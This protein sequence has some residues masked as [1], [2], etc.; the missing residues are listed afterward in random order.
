MYILWVALALAGVDDVEVLPD[1]EVLRSTEDY[2]EGWAAGA[3]AGEQLSVRDPA[4]VGAAC[5]MAGGAGCCFVGPVCAGPVMATPYWYYKTQEYPS[6]ELSDPYEVGY[7]E[8]MVSVWYERSTQAALGG[9]VIGG[10]VGFGLLFSGWATWMFL[11]NG[12][13]F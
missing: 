2:Q 10:T 1:L 8:G 12:N 13:V 9:A 11:Q 6:V 3:L 5:G 4:M 7:H